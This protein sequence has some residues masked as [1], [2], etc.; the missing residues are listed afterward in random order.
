MVKRYGAELARQPLPRLG[1][2]HRVPR[3]DDPGQRASRRSS[4][5]TATSSWP[6]RARTPRSFPEEAGDP[7]RVGHAGPGRPAR[8]PRGRG[9]DDG[10]PRRA[11]DRHR[12]AA[13]PGQVVRGARRARRASRC[14]A[15]RGRPTSPPSGAR[16]TGGSSSR[17]SAARSTPATCSSPRTATRTAR[18][19]RSAA[20]SSRSG[21]TSSR[22]SPSR[23]TS[24]GSCRRP[25]ARTSTP[26][27]SCRT[28]M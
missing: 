3:P 1:G 12:R 19:R 6:G 11:G 18:R 13:P 14:G 15:A 5:S 27:T 21:R 24:R 17:R 28:G 2:G 20:G 23:R 10:V 22:P 26:A 25:A 4:G 7:H 16:P 9:R 8:E